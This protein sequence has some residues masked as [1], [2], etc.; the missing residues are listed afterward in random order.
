MRQATKIK[1]Q[2]AEYGKKI[3]H[4]HLVMG[5]MGNTSARAANTIWIKR[6]GSWLERAKTTDFIAVD[7]RCVKAA[8][9]QLPSKEIFLHLGCYKAR[10]DIAAVVHTHPFMVTALGTAGV[11]LNIRSPRLHKRIGSKI[12]LLP[13]YP[14][15][16][17]KLAGEVQRAIKKANAVILANHGL[18]TVGKNIKEAY[19]RS[20]A[21]EEEAARTLAGLQKG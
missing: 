13:Y 19:R 10:A 21:C 17:K 15:G 9:G 3:A 4:R 18:V 1:R 20:L 7:I 5:A 12:A 8:S 16:S 2:L 11:N 6:G 14:P